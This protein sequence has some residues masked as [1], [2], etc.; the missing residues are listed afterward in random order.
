[1]NR[2]QQRFLERQ[3][4][5]MASRIM[6]ANG[7]PLSSVPD[8]EQPQS[9]FL[10]IKQEGGGPT[11]RL[12]VAAVGFIQPDVLEALAQAIASHIVKATLNMAANTET[13]DE[14]I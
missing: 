10:D 3:N 9:P 13:H 5:K 8:A 6:G 4:E 7:Q 2:Q 11:F 1:M 12:P 14:S